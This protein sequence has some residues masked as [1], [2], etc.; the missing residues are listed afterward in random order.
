MKSPHVARVRCIGSRHHWRGARTVR[1]Y[2]RQTFA[3]EVFVPPSAA[4]GRWFE[5]PAHL[6]RPL[7]N[8]AKSMSVH[9]THQDLVGRCFYRAGAASRAAL[10][11]CLID[12][13]E[14]KATWALHRRANRSK[15][16]IPALDSRMSR[17]PMCGP[18][19]A[20]GA[21]VLCLLHE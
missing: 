2:A 3:R 6:H 7:K 11:I 10:A 8:V 12:Q 19:R 5:F 20:A 1:R 18:R 21:K 4:G 15:H 17:R 16:T 14:A 13:N 9:T